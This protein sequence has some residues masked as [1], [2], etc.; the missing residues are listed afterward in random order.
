MNRARRERLAI[1]VFVLVFATTFYGAGGGAVE[2]YVNYPSWRTIDDAS[3]RAYR[4]SYESLLPIFVIPFFASFLLKV[5]LIFVRPPNVPRW[6]AVALAALHLAVMVVTV[7][8]ILPRYQLPL[9]ARPDPA[10]IEGLIASDS[11]LRGPPSVLSLVLMIW[12]AVSALRR[13][14]PGPATPPA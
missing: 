13:E 9:D 11:L 2:S 7:T 14:A 6:G 5:L 1:W 3:W 8:F 10:L 12:L 4:A